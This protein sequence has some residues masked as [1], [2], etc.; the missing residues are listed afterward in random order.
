MERLLKLKPCESG[1][2]GE[3]YGTCDYLAPEVVRAEEQT[4]MSDWW[5]F[6]INM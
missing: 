5:A 2:L 3:F 1:E 4:K 6:G